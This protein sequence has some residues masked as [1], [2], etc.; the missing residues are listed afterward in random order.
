M[1]YLW[2]T[3]D[4][5]CSVPPLPNV[6][7]YFNRGKQKQEKDTFLVLC[8]VAPWQSC[9]IEVGNISVSY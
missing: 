1:W 8:W 4:Y 9:I 2:V 7:N 3:M 5:P 6:D